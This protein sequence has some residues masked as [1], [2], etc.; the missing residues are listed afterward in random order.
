MFICVLHF[1]V[2]TQFY[3]TLPSN[4]SLEYFPNNTVA[5]FKVALAEAIELTGEWK[6]ALA[7]NRYPN[8]WIIIREEVQQTFM[9]KP[10]TYINE[11]GLI[12]SAGHY[13]TISDLV[14][15]TESLHD[16]R[17]PTKITFSCVA[18][19]RKVKI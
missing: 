12:P 8:S 11:I 13:N 6:V 7:E 1:D 3:L 14:R 10:G 2:A 16:E 17:G 5:N 18:S 19:K 4:S 15:S 9:Y